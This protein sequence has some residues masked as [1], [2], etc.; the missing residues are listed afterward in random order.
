MTPMAVND[1]EVTI[2]AYETSYSVYPVQSMDPVVVH[3]PGEVEAIL[4]QWGV[5]AT[6]GWR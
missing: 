4:A 6:S 5:P 3:T 2:F 1:A